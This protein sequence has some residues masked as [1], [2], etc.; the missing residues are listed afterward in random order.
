MQKW[1]S[2]L[3]TVLVV[4]SSALSGCATDD[5]PQE[6]IDIAALSSSDS[7]DEHVGKIR[8]SALR[9]TATALGAQGGLAWRADQID[10]VLKAQQKKLDQVYNF[11]ALVLQDNV[12]PPVLVE[13]HNPLNK[14]DCESIRA[15]D[16]VYRIAKPPCFVTAPPTWRE[17][18]YMRYG[19]PEEPDVTLL[20]KNREEAAAWNCFVRQGWQ[21]GIAQA[22]QIFKANLARLT[23]DYQGMV[24]YH[25]LF[26]KN[27]VTAPFVA[28]ANLGVTG[29]AKEMRVNDRVLR[30][31]ETSRLNTH[32]YEWRTAVTRLQHPVLPM[33][34][35]NPLKLPKPGS[36]Q[37]MLDTPTYQ[38]GKYQGS[39]GRNHR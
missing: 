6:L 3:L 27:M 39:P 38:P 24:N 2:I 23:R 33:R 8:L 20:P 28:K 29:D 10:C 34:K 35:P 22:N 16:I 12:M 15:A 17:Y 18:L 32:S 11:R 5:T 36:P 13:G 30:I 4:T 7:G 25:K 26:A 19:K 31:A 14:S 21:Q 1:K 9:D 37:P